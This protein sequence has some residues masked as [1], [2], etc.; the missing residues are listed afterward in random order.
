[1]SAPSTALGARVQGY[2][3]CNGWTFWHYE[4]AC[5]ALK[6]IDALRAI[7]RAGMAGIE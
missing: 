1:M 5:Y 3:A 2:D 7:V 4:D 6:P